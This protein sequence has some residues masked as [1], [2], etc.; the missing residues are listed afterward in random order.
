MKKILLTS[1][2]LSLFKFSFCQT[3]IW[4]YPIKPT[5]PEWKSLSTVEKIKRLQIPDDIKS[6]IPTKDLVEICMDYPYLLSFTASN[7]PVEGLSIIIGGFNGFEELSNRPDFFSNIFEFYKSLKIL[8]LNNVNDVIERIGLHYLVCATEIFLSDSKVLNTQ[9]R[10]V[11]ISTLKL[12]FKRYKEEKAL[13][14][15]SFGYLGKMT[16]IF[17]INTYTG[18]LGHKI[19]NLD[20]EEQGAYDAFTRRMAYISPS[21]LDKILDSS[22]KFINDL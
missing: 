6:R 10:E 7:N 1:L 18:S 2:F 11:K 19:A 4:D 13:Q 9:N 16:S 12:L 15:E 22:E 5:S 21:V 17:A 20:A 14:D 8:E 3:K